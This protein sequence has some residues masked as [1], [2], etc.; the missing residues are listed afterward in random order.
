[1]LLFSAQLL[2]NINSPPKNW[3]VEA[4]LSYQ[5]QEGIL[6]NANILVGVLI[7]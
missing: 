3:L 2:G 6:E 1:M 5:K 4:G 7:E